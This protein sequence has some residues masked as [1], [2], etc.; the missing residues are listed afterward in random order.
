[1]RPQQRP[2]LTIEIPDRVEMTWADLT[3]SEIDQFRHEEE[4]GDTFSNCF[5]ETL[6]IA[7]KQRIY[8]SYSKAARRGYE[9]VPAN[10]HTGVWHHELT[11]A[12]ILIADHYDM[13][14]EDYLRTCN[15]TTSSASIQ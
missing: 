10:H 12:Q 3:E 1:M 15:S 2:S 6:Y 4:Q 9:P 11:E 13:P 7:V 14:L 8:Y 5:P